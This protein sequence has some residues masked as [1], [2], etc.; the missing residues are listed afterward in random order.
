MSNIKKGP[1]IS[2]YR[3]GI[4]GCISPHWPVISFWAGTSKKRKKRIK[5]RSKKS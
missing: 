1:F 4:R 2:P 3:I 5:T